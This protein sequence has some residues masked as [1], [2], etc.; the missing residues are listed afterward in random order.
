VRL[1]RQ[2]A[3][4]LIAARRDRQLLRRD[5]VDP[6]LDEHRAEPVLDRRP[7]PLELLLRLDLLRVEPASDCGRLAP[8]LG[9]QR[10]GERV[11]GIGGEDEGARAGGGAAPRGGGRDRGLPH[12][13][14]ARVEDRPG[15]HGAPGV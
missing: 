5:A 3:E 1:Q 8:H 11:R 13:A 4:Q 12:A 15:R 6:A 7:V 9:L 2:Q 10:L 14:L